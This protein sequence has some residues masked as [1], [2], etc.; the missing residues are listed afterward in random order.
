MTAKPFQLV[1]AV[2]AITPLMGSTARADQDPTKSLARTPD[3]QPDIQGGWTA[4]AT[5]FCS[6]EGGVCSD[7]F[8][9]RPEPRGD[10]GAAGGTAD[11]T[12]ARAAAVG[13]DAD[14]I[15]AAAV[16]RAAAAG[17]RPDA[18]RAGAAG[19]TDAAVTRAAAG[20]RALGPRQVITDPPDGKIPYQPWA[21]AKREEHRKNIDDPLS[22]RG[23]DS[24]Y[25][26]FYGP[27]RHNYSYGYTIT[28]TPGFVIMTTGWSHLYRVIPLTDRPHVGADVKLMMGDARGRWEGNTLVVETTN[29]NDWVWFD[30]SGSFHSDSMRLLERF[31]VLDADTIDYTGTVEDPVVLTRSFTISLQLR[32]LRNRMRAQG[33]DL[34]GAGEQW[35]EACVEGERAVETMLNRRSAR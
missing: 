11:A 18:A 30:G 6:I 13:A 29:L 28:Q 31:T 14:A 10:A 27:P 7:F 20:G 24:N 4:S 21:A 1:L 23:I 25:M 8:R 2:L 5:G 3:G 26:C 32:N 12:A 15:K 16:A 34:E 35:E 33:G 19:G 17:G 22:I 9:G